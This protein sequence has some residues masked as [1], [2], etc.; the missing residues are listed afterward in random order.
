[1]KTQAGVNRYL[2]GPATTIPQR[3]IRSIRGRKADV[4]EGGIGT[5]P[6]QPLAGASLVQRSVATLVESPGSIYLAGIG[7]GIGCSGLVVMLLLGVLDL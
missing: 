3:R 7:L 6:R 5:R 4:G 1:M 2:L